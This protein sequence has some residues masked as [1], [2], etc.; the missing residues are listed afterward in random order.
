MQVERVLPIVVGEREHRLRE[1]AHEMIELAV[2]HDDDGLRVVHGLDMVELQGEHL[3]SLAPQRLERGHVW[4]AERVR[5]EATQRDGAL[6]KEREHRGKRV[7]TSE[8][9]GM[10]LQQTG[11]VIGVVARRSMSNGGE[12]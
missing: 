10:N 1:P 9:H 5:L 3:R 2:D 6:R 11:E 7:E 12:A 4:R 8:C